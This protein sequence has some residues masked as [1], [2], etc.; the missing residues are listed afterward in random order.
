MPLANTTEDEKH[1]VGVSEDFD[2]LEEEGFS[3]RRFF[4]RDVEYDLGLEAGT[5]MS[6]DG[7][8]LNDEV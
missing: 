2:A 7:S 8:L 6:N 1:V 5:I 4:D 3:V